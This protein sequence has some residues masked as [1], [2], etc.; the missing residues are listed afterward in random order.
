ML[1]AKLRKRL[2]EI[3]ESSWLFSEQLE[4][5]LI[6]RSLWRAREYVSGD[7]LDI[8]CG[9]KPYAALFTN[10]VRRHIG[11][12]YPLTVNRHMT[13]GYK[14]PAVDIYGDGESLPIKSDTIDS[15][16]C[17]QVLEHCPNPARMMSEMARVLKS[18][19]HLI[20]TAPQE[21]G[22][23]QEPH[24]YF[25]FTYY[26]LRY[27]AE[28]Q[29]LRVE[30]IEQRGGFWAM[31]GQ[32]WSAYLYDT[33]CRPL[34]RRGQRAAFL[35][36]ASII[37]PACAVTQL[38]ALGLDRLQPIK[39][40]TLGYILVATKPQEETSQVLE[41]CEVCPRKLVHEHGKE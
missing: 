18:G 41:T 5:Q 9:H 25:R 13:S 16:L 24:D 10:R 15:V 4:K 2:N 6:A 7:M 3:W 30:Y 21:W 1:G 26:G 12:D 31:M 35:L 40:N 28:T 14:T 32:R 29:G 17:T 39:R 34:R 19:G 22:L 11:L 36:L 37:L 27:L 38:L 20:L 23:H 33:Y 8:G